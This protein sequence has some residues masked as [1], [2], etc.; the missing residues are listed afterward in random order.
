MQTS[1]SLP[2][3]Q[4]A[5][6]KAPLGSAATLTEVQ[7]KRRPDMAARTTAVNSATPAVTGVQEEPRQ[8]TEV[9]SAT[10]ITAPLNAGRK[11]A[12]TLTEPR[13]GT[14]VNSATPTARTTAVNSATPITAPLSAGWKNA[15][16]LTEPRQGT[17]VNSAT[18]AARTTAV[19]SATPAVTG[20]QEEPRQG[21][22][23][24]SA[25]ED[26]TPMA[27]ITILPMCMVTPIACRL[28][29]PVVIHMVVERTHPPPAADTGSPPT[30]AGAT[31][32]GEEGPPRT[33]EGMRTGRGA[34]PSTASSV[35]GVASPITISLRL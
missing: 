31:T 6:T 27:T 28:T 30:A 4:R 16:T 21:T 19:N 22:E 35:G 29:L 8:G 20:V 26:R 11:N 3:L 9:N 2:S 14:E 33:E 18:P 24:N 15:V 17:E 7:E 1:F 10:P 12:V 23:A 5:T 13:Q 25:M 34:I 32:T